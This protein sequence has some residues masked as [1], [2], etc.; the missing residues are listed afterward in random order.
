MG[1]WITW[2]GV[3]G[4]LAMAIWYFIAGDQEQSYAMFLFAAGL[5]GLGRKIEKEK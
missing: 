5:L 4:S 1:G 2:L 3:V